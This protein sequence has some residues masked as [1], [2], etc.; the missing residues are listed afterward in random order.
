[1]AVG[2]SVRRIDGLAKV[3]GTVEY[4]INLEVPGMLHVK[5]LRSPQPH[6]R[7]VRIDASRAERLRGVRAVLTRDDLKRWNIDPYFGPVV[8]DQPIVAIDRVRYIGD[9]VAAVAAVDVETAEEALELIA[10]EYEPLP[11][12]FDPQEAMRPGAPLLHDVIR[13]ADVGFAD[14]QALNL[15]EGGPN[16]VSHFMLRRGDLEE[17]FRQADEIFEDEF[18]V[19]AIQHLAMEPHAALAQVHPDGRIEV[20]SSTQNP[21]V[22]REQLAEVFRADLANIRVVAPYVGGGYGGKTYPKLE[23][24]VVALAMK[25]R[26]PVRLVLTREEV[27]YTITRHA[28]VTRIKTGVTRDGRLV[29][30]RCELLFDTGAYADIGPRTSKNGGYASGG[31]YRIPHVA[32]DSYCVYTN[33]PPAGAFRGFGVPQVCWAY[34]Q[35]MDMIAERLGMDA[36]DL[37][38]KNAVEEGDAFFTGEILH[39][40]P[41]KT[42][43]EKVAEAIDWRAPS[44]AASPSRRR[45]KGVA[46][47]IKSTM[48]PT[49]SA[50]TL[51]MEEDGSVSVLTGTVEIGQGS[52]TMLAQVAA[53][54][55][56]LP[57]ERIRVVHS[58]TNVTPY[59]QSTSSSRSTFSMGNAVRF[60]AGEVREQLLAMV[61][62]QMEI[63]SEDL[64]CRDGR[65]VPKGSPER[66]VGYAEVIRRH[67]GMGVG[68]LMGRGTFTTTGHLDPRTGQGKASAF[69]FTSA[70][71]CE[72]EVDT[73]TGEVEILSLVGAVNAGKALNPVLCEGQVEGSLLFG[74]GAFAYEEMLYEG[75]QLLNPNLL[76]YRVPTMA[77]LPRDMRT[78]LVESPHREGPMGAIGL[79]EPAVAPVAPAIANA[80]ARAVGVRIKVLPVTAEKILRGLRGQGEQA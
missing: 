20:W 55:L 17:G 43:L 7:V 47:M 31:P 77:D 1:M 29:A 23:P 76:D 33:K 60:A 13:A 8:R 12:V 26:R 18:A 22:I 64:E 30:R 40:V 48:T 5:V 78:I 37:R 44:R 14:I 50:A 10:V 56:A 21:S 59:D 67:F 65:V 51:K 74:V 61:S 3:T 62:A 9:V 42:C 15:G 71:G 36:L 80:V 39:A 41:V 70:V 16:V 58:D 46:A 19:P 38:L 4:T 72:V 27:F 52:D 24:L 79:G 11:A 49:V 66:A 63:S 25:A 75:G 68:S 57:L 54:V 73:D 28:V 69:W 2:E 32:F 35:Q 6:A 53:D 34:E 45:G